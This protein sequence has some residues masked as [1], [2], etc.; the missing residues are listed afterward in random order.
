MAAPLMDGLPK[1]LSDKKKIRLPVQGD[2]GLIPGLGRSPGGGH[3]NSSIQGP[4]HL[5]RIPRLSEAP[6]EVP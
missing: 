1:R 5:H 3:G 2:A 4:C 6:W